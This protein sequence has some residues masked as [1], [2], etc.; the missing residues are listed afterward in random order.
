MSTAPEVIVA[1]HCGME[2]L[3]FTLVSNMAAGVLPKKLS[4]EEVLEAAAAARDRFSS[5]VLA[6]LEH[7]NCREGGPLWNEAYCITAAPC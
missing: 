2:V 7:L 1:G 6:C 5:L 3:G 4:E